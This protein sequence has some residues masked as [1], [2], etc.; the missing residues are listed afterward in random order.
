MQKNKK[1]KQ[2]KGIHQIMERWFQINDD[3]WDLEFVVC[4]LATEGNATYGCVV[5]V[6]G[7]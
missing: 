6:T 4:P 1:K 2:H 7:H 5:T 3:S